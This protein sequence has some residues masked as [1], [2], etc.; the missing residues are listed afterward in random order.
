MTHAAGL[1]RA[2]L[3]SCAIGLALASSADARVPAEWKNC[4]AVNARY[5]HGIGRVGARDH[6]SGDPVTNFKRSN[7]LYQVAKAANRG[8][9]RD[10]DGIA[11]E[12]N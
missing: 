5:P 9:D 2:V 12:Q 3:A 10:G 11:C 8:L 7:H 4:K 1:R 6:T